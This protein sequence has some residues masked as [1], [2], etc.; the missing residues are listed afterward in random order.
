LAV[1]EEAADRH[2]SV[3]KDADSLIKIAEE[4]RAG[5]RFGLDTEFLREKTYRA[6][7]CLAQVSTEQG[8][9]LL[10]PLDGLD[11]A[12]LAELIAD[13]EV[14]VI[15]HAGRQDFELFYERFGAVPKAVFD[16]QV[17]A[18]FAGYGS[19]LPYGRLVDALTGTALTKGESY[20]DW[21]RRPLT[22]AQ[23]RYAADDV[24]YLFEM[25][26]KLR[27]KLL[28]QGRLD[29][30][31]DEM[32]SFEHAGLY[33]TVAAEAWRRVSGRG[34][35]SGKQIGALRE[36][37]AWREESASKRDLPRGWIVKD[38]TLIELARRSPGTREALKGIR[39]LNPREVEKSGSQILE[40]IARGKEAAAPESTPSAPR[41]AQTRARMMSG[42]ADAV[43][44][45][46]CEGAE[47]ATELVST[48]GELEGLLTDIFA[49]TLDASRH[50]LLRGWRRKLAGDAVVA[51]AEGRIAVRSIDKAPYI[52]EVEL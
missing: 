27:D 43:V 38:Q 1:S 19:S 20:T 10:D 33:E 40:A 34:S 29:W 42:L 45:S 8:V 7:L 44:R 37:A 13:P 2:E 16:V 50:R 35:L 28:R 46:R 6:R 3:L 47:I 41:Q 51:L 31:L 36:V 9:Y 24:R 25:N 52:E 5:G 15:V 26:T 39:G 48:R 4:A 21:C 11:L 18:A 32:K 14:E 12:P 22:A 17:A 30:C 49:G 23:L